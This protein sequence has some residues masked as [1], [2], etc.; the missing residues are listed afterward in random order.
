MNPTLPY[1]KKVFH[2]IEELWQNQT[3]LVYLL[4]AML[5][6]LP[7]KHN[8]GS[9]TCIIFLLVCF[10]KA[11]KANF[12]ISKV[13]ILPIFL[14]VLMVLS[15]LWTIDVHATKAGLQKEILVLLIPIAFCFL[16][17]LNQEV[18]HR[19]FKIYS[20]SMVFF[21]IFCLAKAV[22]KFS[23]SGDFSVF[24]YH[25]LVTVSLNAIYVSGFASFGMFYFLVQKNKTIFDQLALVTLVAFVFLLSSKN[26][27]ICDF[28]LVMVYLFFFSGFSRKTK[29]AILVA[30]VL[31]TTTC[32]ASIKPIRDR[33]MIELKTILVDSSLK[34]GSEE[35]KNSIYS[36]SLKQA[37]SQE[38]FQENDFF[39]G[40]AFRVYQT[41]IFLEML[42]DE[43]IFFTGFGLDA[44]QTKI[45]DKVKEHH[46]HH[47]YGVY[48]FHNE[49]V[50]IFSEIG[51]L[52]ILILVCML[53][54]SIRNGIRNKD[55][56]H[57]AFSVTMIVLFLT[58]SFLSR[59]RGIIF[60][61]VLYCLL[62]KVNHNKEQNLL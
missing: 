46:L 20:F 14:Y 11:K 40:A 43:S 1:S 41:R 19:V 39:P 23:S 35:T 37:W 55:F 8:I 50:Q 10:S 33:F 27:I 17:H 53:F 42:Q 29:T 47:S 61:I 56:V 26:I 30:I 16:P 15:L 4:A 25:E 51:F 21:A 45:Q 60:F 7:L 2:K 6:T 58:E 57:I 59:Q 18:K 13:E 3:L 38:Q 48:N 34:E 62:N 28:I 31:I 52:G 36:I 49:Y 24:F 22:L 32:I 12:S 9:M 54:I 5:M 44:A